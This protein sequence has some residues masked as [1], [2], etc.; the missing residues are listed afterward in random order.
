MAAFISLHRGQSA[1]AVWLAHGAAPAE[2]SGC[3]PQ[4][5]LCALCVSQTL[6]YPI[7]LLAQ[8]LPKGFSH[9]FVDKSP[10]PAAR[11]FS[12]RSDLAH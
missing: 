12:G 1:P 3:H 7:D 6:P 2:R 8:P 9:A 4:P 10:I 5:S 11:L